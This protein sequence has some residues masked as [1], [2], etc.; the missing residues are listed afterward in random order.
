MNIE[1]GKNYFLK[2]YTPDGIVRS[3]SDW[4]LV[5][6]I[7]ANNK[8]G[9]TFVDQYHRLWDEWVGHKNAIVSF[10]EVVK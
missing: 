1:V 4:V 3:M 8:L 7:K 2:T 9:Y 6:A 5:T 10:E